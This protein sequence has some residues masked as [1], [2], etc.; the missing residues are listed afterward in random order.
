MALPYWQVLLVGERYQYAMCLLIII[1]NPVLKRTRYL[2]VKMPA[3]TALTINDGQTT[4]VAHTYSPDG[5][6]NGLIT[7]SDKSAAT[8]PGYPKIHLELSNP[9]PQRNTNKFSIGFYN[10][11]EAV[12]D[13]VTA[14]VSPCTAKLD[15]NFA[16]EA[17]EQ[18]RKD[19]LA[20]I[21]NFLANA[22]V[23]TSIT[24]VEPFW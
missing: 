13:G 15:I 20:Y 11:K 4:P 18:Q 1:R 14:V 3:Q 6:K 16:P 22:D 17:T 12:V 7:W 24:K 21:R 10:P 19:T 2:E 9:V 5:Q 23:T 8:Q